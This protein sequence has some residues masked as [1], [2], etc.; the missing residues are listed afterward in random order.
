MGAGGLGGGLEETWPG[1]GR[2]EKGRTA[3]QVL[4][5]GEEGVGRGTGGERSWA[6]GKME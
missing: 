3:E 4:G 2:G 5:E 1:I 6:A